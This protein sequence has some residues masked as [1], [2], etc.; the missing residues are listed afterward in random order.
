[1]PQYRT[2]RG[3]A[4]RCLETW[5]RLRDLWKKAG[6]LKEAFDPNNPLGKWRDA[7]QEFYEIEL[8]L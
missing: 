5:E 8:P 2:R 1:M 4:V 7:I 3:P 6:A